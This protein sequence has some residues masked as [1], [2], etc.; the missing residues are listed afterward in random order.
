MTKWLIFTFA[1]VLVLGIFGWLKY[2]KDEKT[3]TQVLRWFDHQGGDRFISTQAIS[4]ATQLS[5]Q[6]VRKVCRKSALIKH[7]HEDNESWKIAE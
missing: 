3:V 1:C 5:E 7:H 4:S 2:K 6:R